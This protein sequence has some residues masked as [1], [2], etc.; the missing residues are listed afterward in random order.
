[1]RLIQTKSQE[2]M[3]SMQSIL[4][5]QEVMLDRKQRS[6]ANDFDRWVRTNPEEQQDDSNTGK[7]EKTNDK[8]LTEMNEVMT[9]AKNETK[10]LVAKGKKSRFNHVLD[11]Y[12]KIWRCYECDYRF[13]PLCL[14]FLLK[15]NCLDGNSLSL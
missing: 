3:N 14:T 10:Y 11:R 9:E 8:Q 12:F 7:S 5:K 4:Q 13:C 15:I 2:V 6:F 1:M